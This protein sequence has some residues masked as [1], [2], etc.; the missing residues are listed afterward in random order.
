M[1]STGFAGVSIVAIAAGLA[2]A[3]CGR[4]DSNSPAKAMAGFGAQQPLPATRVED[5]GAFEQGWLGVQ[6]SRRWEW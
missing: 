5:L 3:A 4:V 2:L 6:F 1:R